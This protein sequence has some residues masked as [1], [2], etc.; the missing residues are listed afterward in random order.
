MS[1]N[2]GLVIPPF[3]LTQELTRILTHTELPNGS[4]L[5][6]LTLTKYF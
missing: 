1:Q 5:S 4:K 6:S 2:Q 3:P